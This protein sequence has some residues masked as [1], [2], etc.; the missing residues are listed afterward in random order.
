MIS[1]ADPHS[2]FPAELEERDTHQGDRREEKHS[3]AIYMLQSE[4]GRA[5]ATQS[6]REVHTPPASAKRV[7]LVNKL[8]LRRNRGMSDLRWA[9]DWSSSEISFRCRMRS[10]MPL[11]RPSKIDTNPAT[12][13]SMKA[14][15]VA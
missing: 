8:S 13:P 2:H 7:A 15:A 9:R 4:E 11:M 1:V 5:K 12:A 10:T 6:S 3:G 14:G